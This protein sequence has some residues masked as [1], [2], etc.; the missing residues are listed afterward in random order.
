MSGGARSSLSIRSVISTR[1]WQTPQGLGSSDGTA[2]RLP[3]LASSIERSRRCPG[4][5]VTDNRP[6]QSEAAGRDDLARSIGHLSLVIMEIALRSNADDLPVAIETPTAAAVVH[7]FMVTSG[8]PNPFG[9]QIVRKLVDRRQ[10]PPPRRQAVRLVIGRREK[11]GLPTVI[12]APDIGTDGQRCGIFVGA[13]A[14]DSLDRT[15][16]RRRLDQFPVAS[17]CAL[18]G[19]RE[20]VPKFLQSPVPDGSLFRMQS[21]IFHPLKSLVARQRDQLCFVDVSDMNGMSR[22]PTGSMAAADRPECACR[23]PLCRIALPPMLCPA[24]TMSA[25]GLC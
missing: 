10:C 7:R 9:L 16:Q 8:A 15:L 18:E 21:R 6:G 22:L 11:L 1:S 2:T 12:Q 14:E 3:S 5:N 25:F 20:N 19:W 4:V 24:R 13:R 17:G 23:P